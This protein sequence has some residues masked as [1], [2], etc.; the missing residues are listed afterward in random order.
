MRP[1]KEIHIDL[2]PKQD[3]AKGAF[4]QYSMKTPGYHYFRKSISKIDLTDEQELRLADLWE[5]FLDDAAKITN[6]RFEP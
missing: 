2:N 5:N 1:I 6:E 3:G 4:I